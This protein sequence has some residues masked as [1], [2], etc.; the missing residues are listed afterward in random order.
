MLTK[1]EA[2]ELIEVAENYPSN[3][4]D[5]DWGSI[6]MEGTEDFAELFECYITNKDD[7]VL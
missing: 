5:G 2:K 4:G 7:I 6:D 1:S 3:L